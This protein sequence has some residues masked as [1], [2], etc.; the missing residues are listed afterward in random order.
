MT[1]GEDLI[2][3]AAGQL[4]LSRSDIIRI[5]RTASRRYKVFRIAKRSGGER[6]IA[7][8]ARELKDL[9]YVLME[10]VV[11][12]LPVH[13]AAK[14]YRIGLSIRHNAL[15]HAHN[16]FI[17]KMDIKDFF[18]SIKAFDF[19]KHCERY[20]SSLDDTAIDFCCQILFWRE[21]QGESLKLSIGAPS[22]PMVSNSIVYLLDCTISEICSNESASYTRYADDLTFS[23]DDRE[24]LTQIRDQVPL[25]LRKATYPTLYVNWGKTVLVSKR[26]R[27]TV[28]GLVLTNDR[29]VSLG[30]EKKRV[31]RATLH[32]FARGTLGPAQ[33][34]ALRGQL[35]FCNSVE[36]DFLI[37]MR[38][39]YGST[40]LDALTKG[41]IRRS[42]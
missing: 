37:R 42:H 28:T 26:N 38:R 8:P 4:G 22:S 1:S 10:H 2:R 40:V 39:K 20:A 21:H 16:S 33:I 9:Q 17:L 13:D 29:A 12:T 27:R 3:L 25:L 6:V 41:P 15:A 30:H 11:S 35:A 31:I 7:Q 32:A 19:R 23:S 5:A 34:E 14:A 24:V 36:P 18:G